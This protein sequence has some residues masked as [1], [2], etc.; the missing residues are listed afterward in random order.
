MA[1]STI[2]VSFDHWLAD[3]EL[4]LLGIIAYY[5]DSSLELKTVLLTL[6]PSYGHDA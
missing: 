2:T 6:K 4:D 1:R 5:L 3:N